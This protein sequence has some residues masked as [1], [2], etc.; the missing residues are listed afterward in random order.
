MPKKL[1]SHW[2]RHLSCGWQEETSKLLD[3][4][5]FDDDIWDWLGEALF[6][7]HLQYFVARLL[8]HTEATPPPQLLP[9]LCEAARNAPGRIEAYHLRG[10][11]RTVWEARHWRLYLQKNY[12]WSNGN[13]NIDDLEN[14][15][16]P[17]RNK[18]KGTPQTFVSDDVD[19]AMQLQKKPTKLL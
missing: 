7:P 18:Q 2:E 4:L 6:H 3:L 15:Y 11:L 17:L 1:H 5:E 10:G 19:R 12:R 8:S 14:F 16:R 9:G 13:I